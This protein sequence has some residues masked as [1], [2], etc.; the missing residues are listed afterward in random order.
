MKHKT[1]DQ[2]AAQQ[3]SLR[4]GV[5]PRRRKPAR[6]KIQSASFLCSVGIHLIVL[7]VLLFV[8]APADYGGM[9]MSTLIA[10][11]DDSIEQEE[12]SVFEV[13]S[14]DLLASAGESN[15]E[16]V[17]TPSIS[18][19]LAGY[20]SQRT[21]AKSGSASSARGTFFGIEAGG[22]EFVYVV[23]TSRSMNGRRYTR[24]TDELMRSVEQLETHQSF[25]V[26]LFSSGVTQMFGQSDLTPMPVSATSENKQ[27]LRKWL[28]TSYDGGST[29]PRK[30]LQIALRMRPSAIFMLSDG[31]F[32]GYQ[33]QKEQGLL[34]GNS[35]AFSIVASAP[36]KTPIHSIA[37]ED[38]S[39]R[40][41]MKR[42]AEM[43]YGEFR[44]VP[45]ENGI[46]P[47]VALQQARTAM[48]EGKIDETQTLLKKA[49][50]NIEVEDAAQ[51]PTLKIQIGATLRQLAEK[52]LEEND[53][54]PVRFALSE[55][56][57][58]DE[59][60]ELVGD[61]Q[62]WL[63]DVLLARLESEQINSDDSKLLTF[64]TRLHD[65]FPEAQLAKTTRPRLGSALYES[66]ATHCQNGEYGSA[67]NNLEYVLQRLPDTKV[68]QR[69][70]AEHDRIGDELLQVAMDQPDSL[71]ATRF[72]GRQLS[73][74][75]YSIMSSKIESALGKL[76]RKIL[77]EARDAGLEKDFATRNKILQELDR[78][79]GSHVTLNNA[80]IALAKDERAANT[81]LRNAFQLER[82]GNRTAI[83]RYRALL[84]RYPDTL[85]ARTAKE[86][87]RY[88]GI[89]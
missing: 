65:D 46:D 68:A 50:A 4:E 84:N 74:L 86:R 31:E 18:A 7:L 81:M 17:A 79:L 78:S 41:N 70:E 1:P 29:D 19:T 85:A 20:S 82:S 49:V 43:T 10:R 2:S 67:I 34:G 23:D 77:V 69:C 60:A 89:Q 59:K 76:I 71:E 45:M 56:V 58:M 72:L 55:S 35:D 52:G 21:S 44:F 28:K 9:G 42:L 24:A 88:V 39:S 36:I 53:L 38:R 25:Y 11:F 13:S 73:G 22:H 12:L 47:A 66:T 57:R 15:S 27:R 37:F 26:L 51:V 32:N 87:L 75:E 33:R 63:A 62:A 83:T 54:Q 3:T 30:A 6:R 80:R 14:S 40:N 5:Q 48:G 16:F 64:F 8:L 61:T